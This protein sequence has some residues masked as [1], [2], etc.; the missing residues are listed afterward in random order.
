MECVYL[1][2]ELDFDGTPTGLYKIGR[3]SKDAQQRKRQY[4]AGNARKVNVYFTVK[5]YDSQAVET[6]LHRRLAAYRLALGGGDEWFNFRSVDI[7]KVVRLMEEYEPP[8]SQPQSTPTYFYYREPKLGNIHPAIPAAVVIGAVFVVLGIF[9]SS[10]V[11]SKLKTH[12][13]Q[14]FIPLETYTQRS[15]SGQYNTAAINFKRLAT[16]ANDECLKS[17]GA[18]MAQAA[19]TA[20]QVLRQSKS[21]P[22][23]WKVFREEQNAAWVIAEPCQRQLKELEEK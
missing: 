14:A 7:A 15:G 8:I 12:Y 6:D 1:L 18:N 11:N 17:Y 4:Q 19:L 20:D 5:V 16:D 10:G 3:T 22:Q 21:H 23:A 13:R 2:Q 9:S